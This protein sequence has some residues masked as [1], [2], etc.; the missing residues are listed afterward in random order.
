[1]NIPAFETREKK[2][3]YPILIV[4]KLGILGKALATQISQESLVIFVSGKTL[5]NDNVIHIPYVKKIPTIPDNTYSHIFII[6]EYGIISKEFISSF[7]K[8]AKHDN[9][10]ITLAIN[11]NLITEDYIYSYISS[12]E[13]AKVVVTGDIFANNIIYDSKTYINEFI[14]S[15]IKNNK[16]DIPGDGTALTNPVYFDDVVTAALQAGFIESED[17]R[18]FFAYPS[19]KFSLMSL[20]HIFQKKDP[21]VKIDFVKNQKLKKEKLELSLNGKYLLEEN[22]DLESKI[23]KLDLAKKEVEEVKRE[24]E[25]NN[26]SSRF[27]LSTIFS[28]IL[29]TLIFFFILPLIF[30]FSFLGIGGFFAKDLISSIESQDLSRAKVS[31]VSAHK[32]FN[33]AKESFVL[34]Q[35]QAEILGQE[36]SLLFL[37]DKINQGIEVSYTASSLLNSF[38]NLKNIISAKNGSEVEFMKALD[39]FK[40][41]LVVYQKEK[42]QGI[43]PKEIDNKLNDLISFASSTI[44]VWPQVIGFNGEKTYLVL[45]QNNME[46]RPGGGFIG[47]FAILKVDNGKVKD[48]KILD[49][50]D[51]DGQLKGHVEPPFPIRRYLPS[52]HWYL[53]DSNFD[54]DFSKSAIASAVFLNTEMR[55]RVDGVIGVD[56]SFVKNLLNAIGPVK[57]LDYNETITAD[58]LFTITN[59]YVEKDFFP[60]STKKKDFLRSLYASI[61]LKLAQEK[62]ISYLNILNA[63]TKS[64]YEKHII[65]AFNDVSMQSLFSV[66]GFGSTITDNRKSDKTIVNDIVGINEANLSA[67][68]V[69]YFITRSLLQNSTIAN[70][71]SISEQVKVSIKN[72]ANKSLGKNGFYKNYLRIITPFGSTLTAVKIDGK[73]Q[74]IVEPIKDP[75]VY[76]K[77]TFVPPT[78]LEV[79]KEDQNGKTIYGFLVNID[80]QT[81][82]T[83]EVNYKLAQKLDLKKPSFEYSLKI[84]KQPGVE[85]IPYSFTLNLSDGL[86]AINL[87]NGAKTI[88]KKI[89]FSKD[90]KRDIELNI[91]L[92]K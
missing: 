63:L 15:I 16:I 26:S 73:E 40:N 90:L 87:P 75:I 11:I 5:E 7:I 20:A 19:K 47:S 35:R 41:A 48:F 74:K 84:F 49:V 32:F 43:I 67:N 6:D 89:I 36:K 81:L 85:N 14:N 39:D 42:K 44:D 69:N 45:L 55:Q 65:F 76:E 72:D 52:V 79:N 66:N 46:L 50:Y 62:N 70:D 21:F 56:L 13:K 77:K 33:L 37:S 64:I 9:S 78:G 53:R 17:N 8:K 54:V 1:M 60:G 25:K 57:V 34:L 92:A 18:V 71:G 38:Q 51:A 24:V 27:N 58:N 31:A 88:D 3:E 59:Y 86:S 12:Y 30:T 22:Y 82:K 83:I 28:G 61:N 68:K 29:L 23:K 4:D 2:H 10:V 80:A 91:A